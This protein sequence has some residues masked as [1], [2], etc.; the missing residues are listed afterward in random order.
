[1]SRSQHAKNASSTFREGLTPYRQGRPKKLPSKQQ[2]QKASSWK[3]VLKDVVDATKFVVGM[4][5]TQNKICDAR[6][7]LIPNS[8]GSV[9]GIS[10]VAQGTDIVNRLGEEIHPKELDIRCRVQI[11]SS[12]IPVTV[13]IIV[14]RDRNCNGSVP[15]VVD[16]LDVQNPATTSQYNYF[17]F[18]GDDMPRFDILSDEHFALA[19]NSDQ[20]QVWLTKIK[21]PETEDNHIHYLGTGAVTTAAGKGSLFA[22]VISDVATNPPT[23]DWNSRLNF[24]SF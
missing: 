2:I 17:N 4:I 24:H 6:Q 10:L 23:V 14:F 16:V 5:N 20:N 9:F 22:L 12:T 11:G 7:Q 8:T 21:F 19:P 13:R 18:Q 1:M 3:T 15:T